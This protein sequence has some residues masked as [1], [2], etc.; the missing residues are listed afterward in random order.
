M[1]SHTSGLL[2]F[3]Q[4]SGR[5]DAVDFRMTNK[6]G[7]MEGLVALPYAC[8]DG[9]ASAN[10]I[11]LAACWNLCL[12]IRTDA[13]VAAAGRNRPTV[14]ELLPRIADA[15]WESDRARRTVRD[16]LDVLARIERMAEIGE[17]G[18]AAVAREAQWTASRGI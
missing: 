8:G 5:I 10:G 9:A 15:A 14:S 2:E 6:R 4:A 11:R 18:I 1:N 7:Y 13:I 12:G 16:L 17:H 3:D